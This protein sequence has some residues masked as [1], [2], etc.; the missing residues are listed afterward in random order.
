MGA[1]RLPGGHPADHG[2]ARPEGG[3]LLQRRRHRAAHPRARAGRQGLQA[4]VDVQRAAGRL[5]VA[6]PGHDPAGRRLDLVRPGRRRRG[7]QVAVRR[8]APHAGRT[9]AE[10]GPGDHR[11][12]HHPDEHHRADD[13][14]RLSRHQP[15]PAGTLPRLPRDGRP[16]RPRPG[17]RSTCAA[18]R[19][20]ASSR[21]S[22][23]P[24]CRTSRP[25]SASSVAAST[26]AR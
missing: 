12:Q 9:D 4:A 2:R 11:D 18:C 1:E 23:S 6:V 14:R 24:A 20:T 17:S 8:H 15:R 21:T 3:R 19:P 16:G 10:A 7:R 26:P 13:R 22:S 25:S 5:R